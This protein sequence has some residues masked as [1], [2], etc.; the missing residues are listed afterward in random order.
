VTL[1]L[2]I[3]LILSAL[4]GALLV[5]TVAA[6]LQFREIATLSAEISAEGATA[7]GIAADADAIRVEATTAALGLA[8]LAAIVMLFGTWVSSVA[9]RLLFDRLAAI[10]QAVAAALG[11]DLVRRV[12]LHGDDELARVA[13]A[14]D[15]VLDSRDIT[16]AAMQGRNREVRAL[17]V[18]LLNRSIQ[19]A[20]IMGVDGEIIVS[21][22]G[23]AQEDALRSIATQ[24][25]A[26]ARILLARKFVTAAELATDIR[27][28]A[29]HAVSIRALVLGEQRIVGWLATFGT[30]GTRPAGV[31]SLP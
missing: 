1:R 2:R 20:A 15:R 19:P 18:A 4:L 24:V 12:G 30:P 17:L 25:R 23:Q 14:I 13:V 6:S 7:E 9:K 26:A 5:V 31:P 28:D 11:G 27:I 29:T 10:D 16:E 3:R 8:A 21:T 22:L